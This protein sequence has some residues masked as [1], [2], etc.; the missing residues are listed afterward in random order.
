MK[1][2]VTQPDID[3][4]ILDINMPR[5]NGEEFLRS[6]SRIPFSDP[7]PAVLVV[8]STRIEERQTGPWCGPLAHLPKPFEAE[9]FC[10]KV[11]ELVAHS[12]AEPTAKTSAV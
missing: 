4:I 9:D 7:P 8:S 12:N 6:A 1:I 11:R 2:L 10:D 3:L 5:M